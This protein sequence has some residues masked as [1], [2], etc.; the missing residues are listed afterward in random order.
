[1]LAAPEAGAVCKLI[2][3]VDRTGSMASTR[4]DGH[5]RCE[6]AQNSVIVILDAYLNGKDFDITQP[7]LGW[8]TRVEY[9]TNCPVTDPANPYSSAG[10]RLVM[11]REFQGDLM[12]SVWPGDTF[13]KVD[14][15]LQYM[16]N[17]SGW[18]AAG[19]ISLDSCPGPSTPMAQAMC[20]TARVFPA[21]APPAG[22]FR[23]AKTT[24]D[25]GEN[26]SDA[27]PLNAGE[28][29]C[30]NPGE[31]EAVWRDRVKNEY[32]SRSIAADAVLWDVGGSTTLR[33]S[34]EPLEPVAEA[35][36][37]VEGNTV[38]F[39]GASAVGSP[40]YN[41]FVDMAQATRGRFQFVEPTTPVAP[42]TTNADSDQDGIPD[43]RD[44]CTGACAADADADGI[45]DA[46]DVVCR[47]LPEDGR[48]P[49]RT[50]GC[51]DTDSDGIRNGL[52]QCP[53]AAEDRLAPYPNDGCVAAAWNGSATPNLKT[54]DNGSACTSLSVTSTT[55]AASQVKL[56]ISGTHA[57]RSV[58]RGTLYHN[59]VTVPAFPVGTFPAGSG[60]FSLTNHPVPMPDGAASGT[61]TLCI[62]DT[63]AFGDTGVLN[64]WSVHN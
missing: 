52:D 45:P 42:V 3:N 5:T 62:F 1:M 30:R 11:V 39:A 25:G 36:G 48:S 31:A 24:T 27:V 16:L 57:Y 63:D 28:V 49:N 2:I 32:V 13:M 20:R 47:F 6:V 23:I 38:A 64:T 46:T 14:Q 58:L 29:R 50:D 44:Q 61:W 18:Y 37:Y 55:G 9:D 56:N 43:Y 35:R 33:K 19:G 51:P 22:E 40:D 59:N 7:G 4:P 21:G 54:V 34:Q 8:Q 26:W 15:A 41:F 60:T 10:Q 12:R 17:Q 53:T